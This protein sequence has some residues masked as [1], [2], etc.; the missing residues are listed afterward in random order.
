MPKMIRQ[1]TVGESH[2]N[3]TPPKSSPINSINVMQPMFTGKM[4]AQIAKEIGTINL[5]T[6]DGPKKPASFTLVAD[7][8]GCKTVLEDHARYAVP[9]GRQMNLMLPGERDFSS[10]MLAGDKPQNFAQKKLLGTALAG[11]PNLIKSVE[12]MVANV[13]RKLLEALPAS[14]NLSEG[15]R[16]S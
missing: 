4:N 12:L 16:I 5:Y 11:V 13:G 3:V 6:T 10:F 9:W 15:L 2:A 14:L 7:Y 8:E 1:I